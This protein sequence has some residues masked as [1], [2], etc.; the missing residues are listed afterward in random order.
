[1]VTFVVCDPNG[2]GVGV[3]PNNAGGLVLFVPKAVFPRLLK[4]PLP[5]GVVVVFSV[6]GVLPNAIVGFALN[7]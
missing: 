5:K 1:M 4:S 3:L 6:V 2:I 7:G